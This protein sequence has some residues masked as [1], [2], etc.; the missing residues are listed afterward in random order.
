[1]GYSDSPLPMFSSLLASA[2]ILFAHPQAS[3]TGVF[4]REKL[5]ATHSMSLDNRSQ[6]RLVNEVFKEN[7]V[8]TLSYMRGNIHNGKAIEWAEVEQPFTSTFS[9]K[10]G[11]TFAFHDDV[12]PEYKGAIA[13]TTNA[14]F[15]FQE[16]FKSDGY[17]TGDG[18]CH[19]ASLMYLVA[20]Q[21]KLHVVA[22]T[23]HSFA[24]IPDIPAEFGVSIYH[25]GEKS[26]ANEV[27]NLYI[28]NTT[29]K[30]IVFEF[31]YNG[32]EVAFSI[33]GQD[34]IFAL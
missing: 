14:H 22:P 7:I 5:L 31:G 29:D 33:K 27:Q 11:E 24:Q 1:M 21:T 10:P 8:L 4:D 30:D 16:G 18:V 6:D 26:T 19:L 17:L 25:S 13:K 20:K 23:N 32:K 34:D 28:K 3:F 9:L 12:L 2:I 15:N